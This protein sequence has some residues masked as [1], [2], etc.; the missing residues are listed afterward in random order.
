MGDLRVNIKYGIRSRTVARFWLANLI[1][2]LENLHHRRVIHR[3]LKPDNILIGR[4]GHLVLADLGLARSFGETGRACSSLSPRGD[5]NGDVTKLSCGTP[6]YMAPE[7][8]Q[9]RSYSYSADIWAV[10][11]IMYTLLTGRVS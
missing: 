2:N 10:G 6:R 5:A 9:E 4:D 3:D 1:V 8:L 11:V 7:V